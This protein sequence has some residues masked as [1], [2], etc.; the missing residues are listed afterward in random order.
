MRT[1]CW[2]LLSFAV[3]APV[4]ADDGGRAAAIVEITPQD[5]SSVRARPVR[6]SEHATL[7]GAGTPLERSRELYRSSDGRLAVAVS[8]TDPLSLEC[9]AA[10]MDEFVYLLDGEVEIAGVTGG[11]Q[12]FRPGDAFVVPHG[13]SGQWRQRSSVR[14]VVVSYAPV[15]SAHPAAIGSS[16]AVIGIDRHLLD[17]ADWTPVQEAPS[18]R[19]TYGNQ[20]KYRSAV[21][22]TS[23]DGRLVVD[24][25]SYEV[26]RLATSEWPIDEFMYFLEGEVEI[27]DAAGHGGV[28]GPGD[29][30][31]TPQGWTGIWK[32]ASP[33]TKIAVSYDSSDRAK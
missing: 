11:R 20:P 8:W 24:V 12:V 16:A 7:I 10:P 28:Y 3:V 1:S 31:T 13:F 33:V 22:F 9:R 19:L 2:L 15:P 27:R 4:L 25:S 14:K 23:S 29:S 17:G 30:I 21:A 32:Q 26:M 5:L 18:A 6:M